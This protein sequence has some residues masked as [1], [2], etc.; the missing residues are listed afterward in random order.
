MSV[1]LIAASLVA[2]T[3]GP[4]SIAERGALRG[5]LAPSAPI[6]LYISLPGQHAE[7]IDQL[8]IAQNTTGTPYYGRYLT[9]Q[10]YGAYFGATPQAYGAA[11]AGLRQHGFTIVDLPENRKDIVASAS[12]SIVTRT[13]ATPLDLRVASGVTF[14]ANRYAPTLPPWL[15]GAAVSGLDDYPVF[16][17]GA[18]QGYPQAKIGTHVAWGPADIQNVYDLTPIYKKYDGTGVTIGEATVGIATQPDFSAFNRRFGLHARMTIV[19]LG[20]GTYNDRHESTLDVEWMAAIA[21][22]A[23]IVQA[24]IPTNSFAEFIK[25]YSYFVNKRSDINIVSTSWGACE[26]QMQTYYSTQLSAD[27]ALMAQAATEGQWWLADAGDYGSDECLDGKT[28]SVNYPASS[29]YVVSVGGTEVTPS[30]VNGRDQYSGWSGEVTWDTPGSYAGAGGGG[31]SILFKKP[32]YQ[33][34]LT[35]HDGNRDVPDVALMSDW[36]DVH[37]AYFIYYHGAWISQWGGT[38]FATP[39]WAAFLALVQQRYGTKKI[40]SPLMRFYALAATR[41]YDALFHDITSGCNGLNN[42]PGYCA[43]EGYDNATGLGSF[44]GAPLEAAY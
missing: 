44:I 28:V 42:V 25:L 29:P 5:A 3:P 10:Q 23:T 11:I 43:H 7:Q 12:A 13:F 24:A 2:I 33:R 16:H 19:P 34:A 21:P 36:N 26:Q 1:L 17:S 35:P 30:S 40:G 39:E 38:S 15:S 14:Y 4:S 31:R 6:T 9:P 22:S 37:G 18:R 20:T 41:H 8:I 27:N 32:A